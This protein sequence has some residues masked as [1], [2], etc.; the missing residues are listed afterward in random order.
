MKKHEVNINEF[1]GKTFQST[2][3]MS[4]GCGDINHKL[5]LSIAEVVSKDVTK[6]Y[7]KVIVDSVGVLT[8]PILQTAIEE[9]NQY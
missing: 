4:Y 9:Y 7:Y 1:I 8:T 5:L 6:F 2:L 3:A